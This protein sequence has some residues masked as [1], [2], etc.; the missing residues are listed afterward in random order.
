MVTQKMKN[1]LKLHILVI[2]YMDP[3]QLK[4]LAVRLSGTLD[5]FVYI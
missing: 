2:A 4:H 5:V 1:I 3:K